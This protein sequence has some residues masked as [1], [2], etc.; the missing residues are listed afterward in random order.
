[1]EF[2]KIDLD[3]KQLFEKFNDFNPDIVLHLAV[4]FE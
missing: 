2:S 4:S 3:E 1:M